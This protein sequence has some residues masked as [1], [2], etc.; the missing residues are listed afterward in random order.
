MNQPPDRTRDIAA[1]LA[2]VE[3]TADILKRVEP[4]LAPQGPDTYGRRR[5]ANLDGP[6]TSMLKDQ[7]TPIPVTRAVTQISQDI[8]ANADDIAKLEQQLAAAREKRTELKAELARACDKIDERTA[9]LRKQYLEPAASPL[10]DKSA[11]QPY[12]K[13]PLVWRAQPPEP[14]PCHP[15]ALWVWNTET[16]PLL[17]CQ[18]CGTP[19]APQPAEKSDANYPSVLGTVAA[20]MGAADAGASPPV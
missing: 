18:T 7:S 9:E 14:P 1:Q 15:S 10:A 5:P 11:E 12:G 16:P 3:R 19:R 20:V 4:S 6:F 2:Q 13:D 17:V 8:D